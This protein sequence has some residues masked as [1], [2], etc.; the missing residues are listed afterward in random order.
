MYVELGSHLVTFALG[1]FDHVSLFEAESLF[2]HIPTF[3]PFVHVSLFGARSP[4]G[5]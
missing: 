3:G 2:G 4:H 1:W 5:A